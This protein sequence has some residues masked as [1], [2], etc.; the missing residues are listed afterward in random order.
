MNALIYYCIIPA[1]HAMIHLC[2]IWHDV[3][4][5]TLVINKCSVNNLESPHH[6]HN[7]VRGLVGQ[8][9]VKQNLQ[10]ACK[11]QGETGASKQPI[12]GQ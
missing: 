11:R 1:T 10:K 6:S 7:D 3:S 9:S 2:F 12:P 4:C 8:A 5:N